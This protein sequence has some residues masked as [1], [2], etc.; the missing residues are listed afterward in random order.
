M[1]NIKKNLEKRSC[2]DLAILDL[3]DDLVGSVKLRGSHRGQDGLLCSQPA[4]KLVL[5]IC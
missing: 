1:Q 4:T 3:C 5:L 2:T